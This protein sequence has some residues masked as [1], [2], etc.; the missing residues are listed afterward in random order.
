MEN[1]EIHITL[2]STN[3]WITRILVIVCLH[4]LKQ[5]GN[6]NGR[7]HFG[8]PDLDESIILKRIFRYRVQVLYLRDR[9]R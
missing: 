5:S 6:P 2:T 1:E 8:G 3:K 7:D 4:I 9:F